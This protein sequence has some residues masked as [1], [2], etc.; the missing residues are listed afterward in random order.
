[1]TPICGRDICIIYEALTYFTST[2]KN[3]LVTLC[4]HGHVC[5]CIAFELPNSNDNDAL[6]PLSRYACAALVFKM[7]MNETNKLISA[8]C[9]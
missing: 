8:D 2:T 6:K 5:I 9:A 4:T 3:V 1:M 7:K